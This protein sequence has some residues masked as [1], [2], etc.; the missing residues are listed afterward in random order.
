MRQESNL[1]LRD[2]ARITSDFAAPGFWPGARRNEGAC[3]GNG[4]VTEA[5][6]RSRAKEQAEKS[7]VILARS[8]RTD[9][10]LRSPFGH[11]ST[12]L[13]FKSFQ[14]QGVFDDLSQV[15]PGIALN[16][17]DRGSKRKL[18]A[19]SVDLLHFELLL[20]GSVTVGAGGI[21]TLDL[22]CGAHTLEHGGAGRTT[23]TLHHS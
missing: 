18:P 23:R 19:L 14:F 21:L 9:E 8:L 20:E 11:N 4:P 15:L 3:P 10:P 16:T 22:D 6:Q 2:R 1:P 7:E 17:M 5:Q 13:H 12:K